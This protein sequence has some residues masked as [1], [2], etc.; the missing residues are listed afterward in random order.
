MDDGSRVGEARRLAAELS[1]RLGF[2]DVLAGRVALVVNELG[3]NL[4]K[5]A[6]GGTLLFAARDL[7]GTMVIELTSMDNGPGMND[8]ETCLRDGYSTTGGPGQGLGAVKRL[9]DDFDIYTKPGQGSL[10]L[11]RF[12]RARDTAG[13]P[14]RS[15]GFAIGAVCLAAPGERVSGDGWAVAMRAGVADMLVAD[16]LGHG[17]SAAEA[18]TAALDLFAGSPSDGPARFVEKAHVALHSTRGAALSIAQLDSVG[19]RI[20]FAG[21]G[22]V[23]ARIVSGIEST[24]LLPENGMAGIQLGTVKE[25][26]MEWPDHALVILYSDGI[27]SRWQLDDAGLLRH[28]PSLIAAFVMWKFRRGNDDA[29]VL[30]LRRAEVQG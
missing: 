21:A 14:F 1:A 2:D 30:V 19:N 17:P 9:A 16:G 29:T 12:Y 10:I 24:L 13:H 27:L 28:D 26:V 25:Q 22:N 11:A 3:N 7:D 6:V 5:H 4:I 15:S 8:V 18:A 23:T 20:R